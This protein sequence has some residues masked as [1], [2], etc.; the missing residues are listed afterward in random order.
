MIYPADYPQLKLIAWNRDPGQPISES[1]AF[2]MYE[3]NWHHVDKD[4]L[5][6]D[7]L[8]LIERLTEV[9]GKGVMNV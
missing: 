8:A 2:G 3:G 6:P 5:E 7:E 9:F 1:D 4:A